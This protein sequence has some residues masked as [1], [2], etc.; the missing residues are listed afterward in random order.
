M[1]K[2]KAE[3]FSG[4]DGISEPANRR[5]S[6]GHLFGD[7]PASQGFTGELAAEG[8]RQLGPSEGWLAYAGV[9]AGRADP[10]SGSHKPLDQGFG[11]L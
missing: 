7:G 3:E 4:S 5:P 2:R 11:P 8:S 10:P 9:V 6:P 1:S